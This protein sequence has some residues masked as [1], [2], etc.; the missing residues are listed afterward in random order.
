VLSVAADPAALSVTATAAPGVLHYLRYAD[1][2]LKPLLPSPPPLSLAPGDA[3][4]A[5]A[6][7]AV[8]AADGSAIARFLHLRDYFNAERLAQALL[9]HIVELAGEAVGVEYVTVLVVEAR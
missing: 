1:A 9:A 4:I 5:V 3:Y 7:G 2:T 8:G 6:P